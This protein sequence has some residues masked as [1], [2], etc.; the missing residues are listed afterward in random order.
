MESN[1][2]CKISLVIHELEGTARYAG[3]LQKKIKNYKNVQRNIGV[4]RLNS[5]LS[6]SLQCHCQWQWQWHPNYIQR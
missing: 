6:A 2:N 1:T 3:L 5:A 4:V